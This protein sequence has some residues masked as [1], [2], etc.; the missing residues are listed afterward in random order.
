MREQVHLLV[1]SFFIVRGIPFRKTSTSSNKL[2]KYS[3]R[4]SAFTCSLFFYC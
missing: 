2:V 3:E 1:L 4:T